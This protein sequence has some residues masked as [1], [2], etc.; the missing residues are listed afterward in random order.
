M[1]R[2]LCY[3]NKRWTRAKREQAAHPLL[4]EAW[5]DAKTPEHIQKILN[6]KQDIVHCGM[7]V[8]AHG[9]IAGQVRCQ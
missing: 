7:R 9:P 5:K 4:R 8:K 2:V 6:K 3:R 1:C